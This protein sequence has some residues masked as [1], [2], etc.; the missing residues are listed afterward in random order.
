MA[1]IYQQ[2]TTIRK[3]FNDMNKQGGC[4]G[5]DELKFYFDSW[6]LLMTEKEFDGI[7]NIF[8]VDKDGKVSYM[9]FHKAIG[10]EITPTEALYFR[11]DMEHKIK[12][13]KCLEY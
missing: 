11:Q 5:R 10:N 12:H 7:Y 6:G 4:I 3:A 9:D 13:T 1:K 8:D 2:W